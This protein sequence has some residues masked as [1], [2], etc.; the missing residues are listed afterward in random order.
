M[1][2]AEAERR[3]RALILDS[4]GQSAAR[5]N[6]ATAERDA[7][8]LGAEGQRQQAVQLAKGQAEALDIMTLAS[9]AALVTVGRAL[10]EGGGRDAAAMRVAESYVAAIANVAKAGNTMLLPTAASDPAAATAAAMSIFN[11]AS[12]GLCPVC[13]FCALCDAHASGDENGLSLAAAAAVN[14]AYSQQP[15]ATCRNHAFIPVA[16][17]AYAAQPQPA[18]AAPVQHVHVRA[19]AL[20]VVYAHDGRR[21]RRGPHV[22]KP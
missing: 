20:Q 12:A 17:T 3:K 22:H 10:Q 1:S 6:M 19:A 15:M 9:S 8:I 2:Q 18:A 21:C 4:E 13:A 16:H 7:A 5:I 11:Q 14:N